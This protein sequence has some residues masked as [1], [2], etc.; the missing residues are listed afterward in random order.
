M[1]RD[2]LLEKYGLRFIEGTD[3]YAILSGSRKGSLINLAQDIKDEIG[4]EI[5]TIYQYTN[6]DTVLVRKGISN[7]E[8]SDIH[9]K[10]DFIRDKVCGSPDKEEPTTLE[11]PGP[12]AWIG[13]P[14]IGGSTI[15]DPCP[16]IK[17]TIDPN[18]TRSHNLSDPGQHCGH[19]KCQN[20]P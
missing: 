2:E 19:P 5:V 12:E 1:T 4:L 7:A 20:S 17:T 6:H 9:K 11:R 8:F 10:L 18:P 14:Q 16:P 15:G 3:D 13:D